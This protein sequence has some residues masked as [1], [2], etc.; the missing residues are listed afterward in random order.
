MLGV[1][2]GLRRGELCALRW[3]DIDWGDG[4][5]GR[6]WIRRAVSGGKIGTPKTKGSIRM[7]DVPDALIT[8]LKT[9]RRTCQDAKETDYLFRSAEGTA[10]DPDNLAKR[11]FVPLV[12]RAKLPGTGLHTLRHTFASLLISHGESIKYVSRQLGHASI[13]ITADTYGHLFKE[14]SIAA[15]GRLEARVAAVEA[16]RLALPDEEPDVLPNRVM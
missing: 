5:H 8:N 12:Q 11:I 10:M 1:Y 6:L 13:Q 2:A 9:Y 14:T 3:E 16:A 15:M 7:I 4:E